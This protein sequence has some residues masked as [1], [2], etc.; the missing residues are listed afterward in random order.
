MHC[1]DGGTVFHIFEIKQ[2]RQPTAVSLTASGDVNSQNIPEG[3]EESKRESLEE[4]VAHRSVCLFEPVTPKAIERN[5]IKILLR[6]DIVCAI[7]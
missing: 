4:G 1:G 7:I 3:E 5:K 2:Q 6:S